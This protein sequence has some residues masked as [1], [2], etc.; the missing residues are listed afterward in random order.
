VQ[1]G[2][3]EPAQRGR[4]Q[5]RQIRVRP[6]RQP[7]RA[8]RAGLAERKRDPRRAQQPLLDGR[9]AALAP[10][11]HRE[12]RPPALGERRQRAARQPVHQPVR[13]Q[14]EQPR[15]LG[16]RQEQRA[17]VRQRLTRRPV[18]RAELV[19]DRDHRLVAVVP[20]GDEHL[21]RCQ[22]LRHGAHDR[23]LAHHPQPV[24]T[25]IRR[26]GVEVR[27]ALVHLRQRRLGHPLGI[28]VEAEHLREV[29][30][31]GPHQLEA[32]ELGP[33]ERMLV[34]QHHA[35]RERLELE[36][37]DEPLARVRSR[38]PARRAR[39]REP[40][41][42]PVDGGP[43]VLAESALGDPSIEGGRRVAVL[44]VPLA[45]RKVEVHDVVIVPLL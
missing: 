4:P 1:H 9:R 35:R 33:R 30:P 19:A 41:L 25:A 45:A 16:A 28:A 40:L 21:L 36:E 32:I 29:R 20:V 43:L 18:A 26:G 24:A 12:P 42:V 23:R 39:E 3:V 10:L 7:L 14:H 17:P 27:R 31:R 37:R 11:L 6:Q 2:D 5:R 22:R 8:A 13:G 15:I 44:G 38:R 34:R